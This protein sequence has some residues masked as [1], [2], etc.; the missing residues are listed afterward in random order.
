MCKADTIE[1]AKI[2]YSNRYY[3]RAVDLQGRSEILAHNLSNAV[4]LDFDWNQ[5]YIY[6]SDVTPAHSE[7]SR[8]FILIC[9]VK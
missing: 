2:I 6:F 5:N 4:A 3:V 7:I 1:K 9:N 8:Y